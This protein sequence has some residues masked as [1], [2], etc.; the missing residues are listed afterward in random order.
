MYFT[1]EKA[2]KNE[3]EDDDDDDRSIM[4]II[5]TTV[6]MIA[7]FHWTYIVHQTLFYVVYK[8]LCLILNLSAIYYYYFHFKDEKTLDQR[9]WVT[10]PSLQSH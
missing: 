1:A 5:L 4:E 9:S 7:S 3:N 8:H 2:L 10:F 6:T